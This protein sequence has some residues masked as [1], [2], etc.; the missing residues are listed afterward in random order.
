MRA[1]HEN[2]ASNAW[3]RLGSIPILFTIMWIECVDKTIQKHVSKQSFG[4]AI[5][6]V[7]LRGAAGSPSYWGLGLQV[8]PIAGSS[9]AT[10]PRP[11]AMAINGER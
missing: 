11:L 1:L 3:K 10:T 5:G 4:S 6:G 2:E 8:A 7:R 9:I